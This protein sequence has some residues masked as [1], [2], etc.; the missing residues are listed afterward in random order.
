M[1]L[2]C[3]LKIVN[4]VGSSNRMEF[5]LASNFAFLV[6]AVWGGFLLHM[7]LANYLAVLM[8]PKF[9]KPINTVEDV[10]E[11]DL[12]VFYSISGG[13]VDLLRSSPNK[14]YQQLAEIIKIPG[15]NGTKNFTE[16]MEE[17]HK[18]P[19]PSWVYITQMIFGPT[20]ENKEYLWYQGGAV[21][22]LDMF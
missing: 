19:R 11:S 12:N 4:S 3:R 13:F 7:L 2:I 17:M 16:V 9:E 22:R 15:V 10:L 5:G 18:S 8:K 1:T 20:L 21:E 14:K 6:W